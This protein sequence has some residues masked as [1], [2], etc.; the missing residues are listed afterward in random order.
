MAGDAGAVVPPFSAS[1]VFKAAN[2]A[3]DLAEAL[4]SDPDVD[5]ALERWSDAETESSKRLTA[6]GLQM[7]QA[8]LW[9]RSRPAAMD[10]G[11]ARRRGGTA[12]SPSPEDRS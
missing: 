1:G 5:R 2:N 3:I 11:Q 4:S 9:T 10:E 6:L 7:E 8:L 12:R